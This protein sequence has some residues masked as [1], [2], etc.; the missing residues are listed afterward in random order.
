MGFI[1]WT[2]GKKMECAT[3]STIRYHGLGTILTIES[4]KRHIPHA[5]GIGTWEYTS[6]WL[7]ASGCDLKEFHTLRDAK[8]YAEEIADDHK[9]D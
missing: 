6:Y 4:R 3:G 2:K 9:V 8:E 5:N 1:T 7:Q